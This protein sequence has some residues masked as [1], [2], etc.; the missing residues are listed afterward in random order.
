M[1]TQAYSMAPFAEDLVAR[2]TEADSRPPRL[3]W[4]PVS[5]SYWRCTCK[6]FVDFSFGSLP[7]NGCPLM[8]ASKHPPLR[9]RVQ[10]SDRGLLFRRK[11]TCL[12]ALR[13]PSSL[14]LRAC[15]LSAPSGLSTGPSLYFAFVPLVRSHQVTPLHPP[16][17]SKRP[18]SRTE[19]VHLSSIPLSLTSMSKSRLSPLLTLCRLNADFAAEDHLQFVQRLQA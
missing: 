3:P 8:P 1:S 19:V 18:L 4:S 6:L 16:L 5:L 17:T 13:H 11:R 7:S 14:V 12:Q 9:S 15:S 2:L 10:E